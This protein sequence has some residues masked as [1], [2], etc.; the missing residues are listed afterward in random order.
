MASSINLSQRKL[1]TEEIEPQDK[2]SRFDKNK[3]YVEREE[4]ACLSKRK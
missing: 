2:V 4:R 3:A 1:V